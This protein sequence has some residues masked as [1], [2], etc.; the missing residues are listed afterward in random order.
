[1]YETK[2]TTAGNTDVLKKQESNIGLKEI[3]IF[4][5]YLP[6][7]IEYNISFHSIS[8]TDTISLR[9]LPL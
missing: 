5:K 6:N 9:A 7:I 1:M 3:L 2:G 4:I 8:V